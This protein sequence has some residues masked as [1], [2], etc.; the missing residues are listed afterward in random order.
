MTEEKIT[1]WMREKV[2][3]TGFTDATSLAESF[4]TEH[5]ISDALDPD[6]SL[7][8]DAGFKIAQ[9]IRDQELAPVAG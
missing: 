4:L 5:H 6:F 1:Q 2:L 9:E 3:Q 8:L 7:S